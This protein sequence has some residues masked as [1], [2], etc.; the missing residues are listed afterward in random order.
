[1]RFCS[2]AS[3]S[4]GNC[5]Y[6]GN[7]NTHLLVDT[8]ISKKR[9]EEGLKELDL[10]GEDVS[11]I[12]ITHEHVDHIQGLG[13]FSRKY[14]VPI[15]ATKGTLEGIKEYKYLGEMPDG[16][17]REIEKDQVF[18]VGDMKIRPFLVSHDA[19]EPTGYRVEFGEKS[20]AVATDLGVYDDYIVNNLKGLNGIVLEA[21]HDV[22]M[23]EVGPYPY[24]LKQRVLGRRGHLSNELS[25]RLLCDILHNDL[26]HIVLGHLSKENNYEQLALE[27]V[28]LE[29]TLANNPYKGE[30]LPLM[31][32][33]RDTI[34][35]IL[36]I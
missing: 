13:V 19:K 11:G 14:K 4:S 3:G 32:A 16:L 7:A 27:T 12:L 30:D 24:P 18:S 35:K 26:K 5:I 10:S 33:S 22:H 8:G 28:K 25:G 20:V 9:I 34:S 15:Y 1:M 2:I 21:N 6:V 31:V 36:Y 17:L 23:L 29:V